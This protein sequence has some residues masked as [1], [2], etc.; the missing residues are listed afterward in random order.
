MNWYSILLMEFGR[1]LQKYPIWYPPLDRGKRVRLN[2]QQCLWKQCCQG[3]SVKYK[4][5]QKW[6]RK[7]FSWKT[8]GSNREILLIEVISWV[9]FKFI[10]SC[11]LS[12]NPF[13]SIFI[14]GRL[15]HINLSLLL[16]GGSLL[17]FESCLKVFSFPLKS[18]WN[19]TLKLTWENKI[20]KIIEGNDFLTWA[21]VLNLKKKK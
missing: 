18:A 2:P 1:C 7:K 10:G 21:A 17:G 6:L 13:F 3:N 11:H 4:T 20:R 8:W 9:G 5:D 12:T 14:S 16:A 19:C 15:Y